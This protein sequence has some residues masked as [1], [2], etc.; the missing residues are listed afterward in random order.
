MGY[1]ISSRLCSSQ[2]RAWLFLTNDGFI[3]P[4]PTNCNPFV[5]CMSTPAENWIHYK[6]SEAKNTEYKNKGKNES[7]RSKISNA[8]IRK[9]S[10]QI[11]FISNGKCILNFHTILW[12]LWK[13]WIKRLLLSGFSTAL[14]WLI[15]NSCKSCSF[16]K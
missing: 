15:F 14:I 4:Q 7:R 9:Q 13:K 5:K 3:K 1:W 6:N 8:K 11:W 2:R 10:I 16:F 12:H